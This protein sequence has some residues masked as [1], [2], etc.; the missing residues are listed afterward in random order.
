MYRSILL[1]SITAFLISGCTKKEG[2]DIS[3]YRI[4]YVLI[5]TRTDMIQDQA[6]IYSDIYPSLSNGSVSNPQNQIFK[7]KN[8]SEKP[9]FFSQ[10][11]QY[12][13]YAFLE[14]D[15]TY[16]LAIFHEYYSTRYRNYVNEVVEEF[17]FNPSA[18]LP[19]AQN[20]FILNNGNYE[21]V[22]GVYE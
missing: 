22:V 11:Y 19:N 21:L 3:K 10:L 5:N 7:S 15:K 4:A 6:G 17:V 2:L 12:N 20:Q 14:K 1:L 16:S 8:P 18:H 9:L 13:Q